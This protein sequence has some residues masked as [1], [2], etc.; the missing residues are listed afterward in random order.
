MPPVPSFLAIHGFTSG[1]ALSREP[2]TAQ[3]N[4]GGSNMAQPTALGFGWRHMPRKTAANGTNVYIRQRTLGE[5]LPTA[6]RVAG[7]MVLWVASLPSAPQTFFG[8][9]T[10]AGQGLALTVDNTGQAVIRTTT[11]ST[12]A[13]RIGTTLAAGTYYRV[14]FV[15]D[16]TVAGAG[17]AS[18]L[19]MFA[20][21]MTPGNSATP[22]Q[23]GS[24]GPTANTAAPY[25]IEWQ[26]GAM[27]NLAATGWMGISDLILADATTWMGQW[28]VHTFY[29]DPSFAAPSVFGGVVATHKEAQIDEGH[30]TRFAG[31]WNDGT[32]YMQMIG[33][34]SSVQKLALTTSPIPSAH[35]IWALRTIDRSSFPSVADGAS[36]VRYQVGY[37]SSALATWTVGTVDAS[38]AAN[39]NFGVPGLASSA[40]NYRNRLHYGPPGIPSADAP[41]DPLDL[42]GRYVSAPGASTRITW[43]GFAIYAAVEQRTGV[44]ASDGHALAT[45]IASVN[46]GVSATDV[47]GVDSFTFTE[48][49]ASIGASFARTD[50]FT[51]S[52]TLGSFT[53]AATRTDSGTTTEAVGGIA[54][55]GPADAYTFSE[56]LG[57]FT[58][59]ATRTDA[60][61]FTEGAASL[62]ATMQAT[63]AHTLTDTRATLA[64]TLQAT[65]P[66]ALTEGAAS[67]G[68]SGVLTDT[69]TLTDTRATLAAAGTLADSLTLTDALATLT[70]T[71]QATDPG[72]FTEAA[73]VAALVAA[74]DAAASDLFTFSETVGGLALAGP[75]DAY[76]FSEGAPSLGATGAL[77]DS[78]ALTDARATLA[79]AGTL[80]DALTLTD[81]R[82]TLAAAG[83][84]TDVATMADPNAGL[85]LSG[86]TDSGALTDTT[87]TLLASGNVTDSAALDEHPQPTTTLWDFT[88]TQDFTPAGNASVTRSGSAFVS[89]ATS[90]AV[91]AGSVGGDAYAIKI[92]AS[93]VQ[94][95]AL[96]VL[97]GWMFHPTGA[98]HR[99]PMLQHWD[100]DFSGLP[101]ADGNMY[102]VPSGWSYF[103]QQGRVAA[104]STTSRRNVA[105]ILRPVY[106]PAGAGWDTNGP[107]FYDDLVLHVGVP[108]HAS[109]ALT[110][111][112]TLTDL[113]ATLTAT[114]ALSDTFTASDYVGTLVANLAATDLAASDLFTFTDARATLAAAV[115]G[116]DTM[117]GTD[118]T[119]ALS[120]ALTG[121]DSAAAV[122]AVLG[123]A[124]PGTDSGAVADAAS[125]VA[126]FTRTDAGTAADAT[127]TLAAALA[128]IDSAVAGEQAALAAAL[129]RTD[130][131]AVAESIQTLAAL[132]AVADA[133]SLAESGTVTVTVVA[134]PDTT[135]VVQL[136]VNLPAEHHRAALAHL[137]TRAGL[138]DVR[139]QASSQAAHLP[140]R[141]TDDT[142]R[143]DTM[144]EQTNA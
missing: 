128:S 62:G 10:Q 4:S 142:L 28:A 114:G 133:G 86:L 119:S 38:T 22:W 13:A 123:I 45:E 59:A 120:A 48:G 25:F 64:A 54:L 35:R 72:T 98:S 144:G 68:A 57:S 23:F 113:T 16:W 63:D 100:L 93:Q 36:F 32:D 29:P 105:I 95:G 127:L 1:G 80:T 70:A 92:A 8:Y 124:L 141:L 129:T 61:T 46:A 11:A 14:E 85:Q 26:S 3:L 82:A 109:G 53:A 111:S 58:A 27:L 81:T 126:Q 5:V 43:T 30:P 2:Y 99:M 37:M 69:L 66:G 94:A 118:S 31:S 55:A 130:S 136:R 137:L 65:D 121:N 132:I 15:A 106:N 76:T 71:L 18:G 131:A 40:T 134:P 75:A 108:V 77:T 88:S 50:A 34:T 60:L 96:V 112:L 39:S 139:V 52:E 74:T 83:T 103:T 49:A 19:G 17:R 101:G 102:R 143:A 84:L 33:P 73:S 78:G 117:S 9:L 107:A 90:L 125:L 56:A 7:H 47:A 122:E 135:L 91:S 97:Q 24:L 44:N 104:A 115:A 41:I 116:A 51:F 138:A 140:A 20:A 110:D 79:A 12:Q 89:A 6:A 42:M 21:R 67:L 87:A